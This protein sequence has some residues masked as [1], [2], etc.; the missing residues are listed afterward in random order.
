[1]NDHLPAIDTEI[2][3]R[4]WEPLEQYQALLA[5]LETEHMPQGA[6]E[7]HLVEELALTI[8]RR[9]RLRAAEQVEILKGLP[10]GTGE[11]NYS[12]TGRKFVANQLRTIT[13]TNDNKLNPGEFLRLGDDERD[14]KMKDCAGAMAGLDEAL[15]LLE[16]G[17][18]ADYTKAVNAVNE[19]GLDWVAENDWRVDADELRSELIDYRSRTLEPRLQSLRHARTI[20]MLATA[21]SYTR[22]NTLDL[23]KMDLALNRK[24]AETLAMLSRLQ[25][26]RAE[27]G[28]KATA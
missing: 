6:T 20:A 16:S 21:Y 4:S 7:R 5:D 11:I 18:D 1:M 22:A 19:C 14:K 3:L 10:L 25:E 26:L 28:E 24:M 23:M 17:K 15:M 13:G 12:D 8:W 9:R 2:P 27:R